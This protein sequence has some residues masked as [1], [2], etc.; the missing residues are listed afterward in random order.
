M[1]INN[2][3]RRCDIESRLCM[4]TLEAFLVGPSLGHSAEWLLQQCFF[5]VVFTYTSG[6]GLFPQS[7]WLE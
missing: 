1:V 4:Y 6:F 5:N 3:H 2:F 7:Y